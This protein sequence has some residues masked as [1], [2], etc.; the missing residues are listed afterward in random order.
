[1]RARPS[2]AVAHRAA[3]EADPRRGSCA[4]Q[5]AWMEREGLLPG[6]GQTRSAR[7]A[8]AR[9]RAQYREHRAHGWCVSCG[10]ESGGASKCSDCRARARARESQ[11][12]VRG[13]CAKCGKRA[14]PGNQLCPKHAEVK[15]AHARAQRALRRR[16]GL[17]QICGRVPHRGPL[18]AGAC[19]T[20]RS[21]LR[22]RKH[23]V[24]AVYTV[25]REGQ[26]R[27]KSWARR[28]LARAEQQLVAR[29]ERRPRRPRSGVA[30]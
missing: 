29:G 23:L 16:S 20:C 19:S 26:R 24:S 30:A 27:G 9:N 22:W 14:E 11:R 2:H 1:M 28:A 25:V 12:I 7:R 5:V 3:D 17:C 21:E 15:R 10:Q 4:D 6:Q 8:L 13:L 18:A